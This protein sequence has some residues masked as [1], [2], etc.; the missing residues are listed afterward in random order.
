MLASFLDVF[1]FRCDFFLFHLSSTILLSSYSHVASRYLQQLVTAQGARNRELEQELKSYRGGSSGAGSEAGEQQQHSASSPPG[2]NS[3]SHKTKNATLNG[4]GHRNG[5]THE[6]HE[7]MLH[8]EFGYSGGGGLPSMP[9]GDDEDGMGMGGMGG[10]GGM[11]MGMGDM[12]GLD[13]AEGD[14]DVDEQDEQGQGQ[15]PDEG[16]MDVDDVAGKERGRTRGVSRRAGEHGTGA[17]GV[18]VNGTKLKEET[19]DDDALAV[20]SGLGMQT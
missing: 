4:H 6:D 5:D 13:M 19:Q 17:G 20:F 3:A 18:T 12:M 7:M 11:G 9:E 14:E 8:D 15:G 2:G 1:C 10:F 16:G